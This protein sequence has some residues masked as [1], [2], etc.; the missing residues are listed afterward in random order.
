MVADFFKR[1]RHEKYSLNI[2][3]IY[4]KSQERFIVKN[5]IYFLSFWT[6][7]MTFPEL[8]VSDSILEHECNN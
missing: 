7:V 8:N 2:S 6:P 5:K 1:S 4:M 3:K